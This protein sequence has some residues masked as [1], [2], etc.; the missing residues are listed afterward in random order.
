MSYQFRRLRRPA[1]AALA[2]IALMVLVAFAPILAGLIAEV[3]R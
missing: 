1:L 2:V 3:V